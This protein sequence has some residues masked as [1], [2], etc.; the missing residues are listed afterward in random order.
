MSK[1]RIRLT[2]LEAIALGLTVIQKTDLNA[3]PRYRINETQFNQ[4]QKIR[5]FY[6]TEFTLLCS[7]TS[8]NETV[9]FLGTIIFRFG[10]NTTRL[11]LHYI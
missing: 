11:I 1:Q 2:E 10:N 3:N 4:L 5:N 7:I 8:F 9:I 6:K